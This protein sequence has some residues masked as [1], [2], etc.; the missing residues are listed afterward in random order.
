MYSEMVDASN[1]RILI[2]S[3][4]GYYYIIILLYSHTDIQSTEHTPTKLPK[5]YTH[6]AER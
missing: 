4:D 3:M 2:I 5:C 1:L 6:N